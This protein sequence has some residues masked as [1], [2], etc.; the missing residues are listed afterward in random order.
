MNNR[1]RIRVLVVSD[2]TGKTAKDLVR[3]G[4]SQFKN[5]DV[6]FTTKKNIRS[7]DQVDEIFIHASSSYDAIAYTIVDS[8]VREYFQ[9]ESQNYPIEVIDIMGPVLNAFEKT[10]D[11]KPQYRPG[12]MRNTD[13]NYFSKISAMEFTLRHD[14]GQHLETLQEADIIL[15]GIS[16]TSKTP[17]SVVLSLEGLKVVNIPIEYKK[18]LPEILFEIDQ[19]KIIGL[20]IQAESLQ[21]IR[22]N[23]VLKNERTQSEKLKNYTDLERINKEIAW[24]SDI[25]KDNEM[26]PVFDITN[27]SLE[28]IAA[29]IYKL[30]EMRRANLEKQSLR[31][32]R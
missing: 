5:K 16:R 28:E 22:R 12:L 2:G 4:V 3:A 32:K 8:K 20:T 27:K 24:A 6:V 10:F 9:Q 25:F 26:W 13:T 11:E 19:R 1:N 18:S 7:I 29:E 15:V 14:N 21:E 30:L 23:R 17:L 31:F